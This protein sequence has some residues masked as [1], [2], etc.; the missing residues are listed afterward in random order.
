MELGHLGY[1]ETESLRGILQS[2]VFEPAA[3]L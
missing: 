1:L 3:R 2:A